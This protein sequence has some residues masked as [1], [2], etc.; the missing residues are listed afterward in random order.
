M[1]ALLSA[2]YGW[3]IRLLPPSAV[4]VCVVVNGVGA[5]A[6]GVPQPVQCC[7]VSAYLFHVC[8]EFALFLPACGH[9]ICWKL[10]LFHVT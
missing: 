3:M 5:V 6:V 4:C 2:A 1:P 8:C 7:C 10:G 9:F